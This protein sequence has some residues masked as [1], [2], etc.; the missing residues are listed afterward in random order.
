MISPNSSLQGGN[1]SALEP[2]KQMQ[3]YGR[4]RPM[5]MEVTGLL[6]FHPNNKTK[7]VYS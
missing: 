6:G 4:T 3:R 1:L 5:R 7:I 2:Q